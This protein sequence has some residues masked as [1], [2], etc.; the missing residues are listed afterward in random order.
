M[1]DPETGTAGLVFQ[2][3]FVDF[4]GTNDANGTVALN[5]TGVIAL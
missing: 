4:N 2:T 3:N 5:L 1:R